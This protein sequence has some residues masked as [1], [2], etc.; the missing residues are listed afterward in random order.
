MGIMYRITL[1]SMLVLI[2]V[3]IVTSLAGYSLPTASAAM[4]GSWASARATQAA[5]HHSTDVHDELA[6]AGHAHDDHASPFDED[7]KV[8]KQDCCKDFCASV[9]IVAGTSVGGG[10]RV[11][12]IRAF[13][14][15]ARA[16]GQIPA[17]HRPPNI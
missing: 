8:V 6:S 2:R 16:L 3:V 12:S 11:A 9:A 4:H 13:I 17:L 5:D 7:Q 15:H 1:Q 10:P 14:D